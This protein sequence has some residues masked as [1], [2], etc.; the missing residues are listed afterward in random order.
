MVR[1]ENSLSIKEMCLMKFKWITIN[2]IEYGSAKMLRW[3]VLHKPL[4]LAP[5]T[6]EISD[7]I[8][9]LHLV[10]LDSKKVVGSISFSPESE[11]MGRMYQ[12]VMS[13]EYRG[14]G[15]GRKLLCTLEKGLEKKGIYYV[16]LY[17]YKEVEGFYQQMG[18]HPEGPIVEKIGIPHRLMKKTLQKKETEYG[19]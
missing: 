19:S 16:Y 13:E 1:K 18:Y 10:A 12:M 14:R 2:H 4:G 7:G 8:S 9:S 5:E 15:F 11:I 6:E 17:A 3:E